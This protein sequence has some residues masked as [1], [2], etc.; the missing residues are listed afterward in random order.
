MSTAIRCLVLAALAWAF[1]AQ[2]LPTTFSLEA[3]QAREVF[4]A[5]EMTDWEQGKKPLAKGDD[6][7][8]HLTLDLAPGQWVYKY[9]V[10]GQWMADPS[11]PNRDADG[12][13]GEH[14]Y[15][16]VGDGDWQAP[17]P[18]TPR[19]RID[20]TLFPSKAWG[21]ARKTHVILPPGF[22]AG[23]QLPVLLLLH[24]GGM[25][26]DQ[27]LKTGNVDRY[28]DHLYARKAL[29]RLVLVLPTSGDVP[30]TGVS[31]QHIVHELLPWLAERYGLAPNGERLAVAGMSMGARGA[32]HLALSHPQRFAAAYG[33]SGSYKADQ[34]RQARQWPAVPLALRC[35][36]EDF[37]FPSH[38]AL[39]QSLTE[40]GV[41]F[42]HTEEPGAHSWHYWS[43]TTSAMLQ[44][45]G[46]RL[47]T[48]H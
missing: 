48:P 22:Q 9:V 25:D 21:K 1:T 45:L 47:T 33:L 28:V 2:A 37:V 29:P 40:A 31:E 24:G 41:R 44:W 5:G 38:Q 23:E 20:T 30:Y 14:S 7:R 46:A 15:R 39:V 32:V 16:L 42:E 18:G 36:S 12:R 34:I 26:A 19:S 8:W 27:W 43:N 11:H 10:D 17:A 4:L 35:G 13:G 6:G 3:P